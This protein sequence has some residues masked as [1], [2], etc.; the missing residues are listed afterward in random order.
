MGTIRRRFKRAWMALLAALPYRS[1][2]TADGIT[3]HSNGT[4]SKRAIDILRNPKVQA[5]IR[6]I[7]KEHGVRTANNGKR[8]VLV[9]DVIA[10]ELERISGK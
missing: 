1:V 7:N 3:I 9:D 4:M 8:Y 10:D 6:A 5:E 2:V